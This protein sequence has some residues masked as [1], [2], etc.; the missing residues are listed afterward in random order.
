MTGTAFLLV[1]FTV[2]DFLSSFA[3]AVVVVDVLAFVA[4]FGFAATFEVM[5]N[6]RV[7]DEEAVQTE[8]S[9][10]NICSDA[11]QDPELKRRDGA[12]TDVQMA[13]TVNTIHA[14]DLQTA[15]I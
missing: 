12:S 4:G 9:K 14:A 5:T 15:S 10:A 2:F 11:A 6:D 13:L 8:K 3:F 1:V 7:A